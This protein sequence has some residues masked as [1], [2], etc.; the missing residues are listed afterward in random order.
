[1]KIPIPPKRS[2]TTIIIM[3]IMAVFLRFGGGGTDTGA[4]FSGGTE[5]ETGGNGG[6]W[7]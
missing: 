3:A 6:L 5:G 1:M 7:K 2:I 4:G